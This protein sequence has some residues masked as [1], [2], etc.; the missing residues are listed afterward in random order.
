[1]NKEFKCNIEN[2]HHEY[3][4]RRGLENHLVKIHNIEI[5]SAQ[6]P[7]P[8]ISPTSSAS[9]SLSSSPTNNDGFDKTHLDLALELSVK[10]LYKEFI[11]NEEQLCDL[12]DKKLCMLCASKIIDT[13]FIDCGHVIACQSCAVKIKKSQK[14]E[15]RCPTCRK[16]VKNIMK[17]YL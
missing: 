12:L 5:E 15:R 16:Y 14:H 2:C 1:M 3:I 8:Q 9:S 17:I 13:A 10:E 4:T 11:P 7:S 6:T